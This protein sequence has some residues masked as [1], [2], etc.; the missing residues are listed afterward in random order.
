MN[1]V[2]GF[3][4]GYVVIIMIYDYGIYVMNKQWLI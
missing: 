2:N 3:D 1:D 4:M